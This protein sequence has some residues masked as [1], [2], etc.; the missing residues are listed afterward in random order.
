MKVSL[1]LRWLLVVVSLISL[2]SF[3]SAKAA[4]PLEESKDLKYI[5]IYKAKPGRSAMYAQFTRLQDGTLLCAFRDS[6]MGPDPKHGRT[7]PWALPGSRIVCIRST[8]NGRTWTD[9]PVFIYQDKDNWAYMSEGGLGHQAKDGII[10]VPF[11]V[12]NPKGNWEAH[13]HPLTQNW[14]FIARSKDNGRTWEC[15]EYT[16]TPFFSNG[17]YGGIV[18]LDD[19]SLWM[20]Q[21]CAGY[22]LTMAK[23]KEMAAKGQKKS[24]A[25]RAI[26]QSKDDGKTWSHYAY[27]GYD[28]TRPKETSHFPKGTAQEEPAIVQLPSG[29]ILMITRPFMQKGVSLDRGRTWKIGP[30]ALTR[31]GGEASGLCPSMWYTKAGPPT[32]TIVLAWHDRW[33]KHKDKGGNY[34][35]FS[36]DE[37]ETWG[38]PIF[39]DGGAYPALYE[40]K[41]DSGKFLCG[42][43]RSSTL[44]KG[45]FFSVPFP[46]GLR[47]I[48]GL[49]NSG[50]MGITVKWDDY[51]GKDSGKYE[52]RVYRSEKPVFPLTRSRLVFSG[53]NVNSY[54]DEKVEDGKK[55]YYQVA[56]CL[57]DKIISRS[58]HTSAEPGAVSLSLE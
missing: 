26:V 5:T 58:W 21:Y 28:P 43:Y 20:S 3:E 17:W 8:N 18:H 36:H 31:K 41:K 16:N 24:R 11:L 14:A 42:Y 9:E 45:V 46:T 48:S 53:K 44:L 57:D 6:K 2:S 40:L 33:G 51:N 55:Y 37:G 47:A 1:K 27:V 22:Q 39:I 54:E 10:I 30:S 29:K 25:C 34:V 13:G 7:T 23:A 32:G 19:G 4:F 15:E 38:Y 35:T 52:Y 12:C 50:R 56:A 49:E